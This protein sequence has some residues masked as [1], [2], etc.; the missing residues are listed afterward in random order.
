MDECLDQVEIESK[1]KAIIGTI[2]E[3]LLPVK[4]AQLMDKPE[5][6]Q[7]CVIITDVETV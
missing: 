3:L 6:V 4:R 1:V 2:G 5:E 7:I